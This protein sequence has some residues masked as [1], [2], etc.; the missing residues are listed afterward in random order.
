M[1]D[2]ICTGTALVDCIFSGGDHTTGYVESIALHPGGDAFNEAMNIA[3]LGGK[4]A[5]YCGLGTDFAGD[6]LAETAAKAGV[7]MALAEV[8]AEAATPVSGLFVDARGERRS[9]VSAAHKIPFFRPTAEKTAGAKIVTMASLFRPPF[10]DPAFTAAFAR[11]VKEM[12][13]LL[14]IDVKMPKNEQICLRDFADTV[15]MADFI[16]P[17][18]TEAAY[19]SG[20]SEPMAQA[21]AFLDCGA[22]TVLLKL[23]GDGCLVVREGES[24]HVPAYD[25]PVA[26]GVGA[27]DAFAAGLLCALSEG[28]PLREACEFA[29]A[30]AALCVQ[31]HGAVGGIQS[32]AQVEAFMKNPP[33]RREK[34]D[35]C[36]TDLQV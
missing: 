27:G 10:N 20:A 12:G 22:K 4:S 9:C 16:S 36:A 25:V 7:D 8:C 23:G 34:L 1:A 3:R 19:Y 14:Y 17:N 26:D 11:G 30:A 24:F 6:M 2:I 29:T 32:R 15:A 5:L 13:A 31:S 33:K 18:E 28:R 21:R 35:F